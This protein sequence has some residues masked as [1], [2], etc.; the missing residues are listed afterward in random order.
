MV[1]FSYPF[2]PH[3][4]LRLPLTKGATTKATFSKCCSSITMEKLT[5][6][7][8]ISKAKKSGYLNV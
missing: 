8:H 4:L 7:K 5:L 1:V 3:R 6:G 2:V